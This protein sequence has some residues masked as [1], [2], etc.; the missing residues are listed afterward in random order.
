MLN[1]HDKDHFIN[2]LNRVKFYIRFYKIELYI[3]ATILVWS[4]AI[5]T[6]AY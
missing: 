4:S 1:K 3:V 5:Y 6:I 2:Y